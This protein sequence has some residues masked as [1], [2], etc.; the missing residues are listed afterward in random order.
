MFPYA[1]GTAQQVLS[2]KKLGRFKYP[3]PQIHEQ[4]KIATVLSSQDKLVEL[5]EKLLAEKQRQKKYLMQQLLTGKRRL[6]GFEG[7]WKYIPA[8]EIFKSITDKNC[9]LYTSDAADE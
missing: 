7:V 8:R 4:Q 2:L 6:P 9:L 1:E 5:K 3:V